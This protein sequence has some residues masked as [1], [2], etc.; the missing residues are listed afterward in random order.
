MVVRGGRKLWCVLAEGWNVGS[1][2]IYM[3]TSVVDLFS[4]LNPF[5][6]QTLNLAFGVLEGLLGWSRPA[7]RELEQ[8]LSLHLEL[9]LISGTHAHPDRGKY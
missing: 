9:A 2:E 1:T 6:P 3:L 8:S 4:L 7:M 5:S